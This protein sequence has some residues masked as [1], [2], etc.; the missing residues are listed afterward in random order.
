M[1]VCPMNR[2]QEKDLIIE[3]AKSLLSS[4]SQQ[5]SFYF[6]TS[7]FQCASTTLNNK[8]NNL[9]SM[10][11][12]PRNIVLEKDGCDNR[13]ASGLLT[14]AFQV[15]RGLQDALG[16]N[17]RFGRHQELHTSTSFAQ[18]HQGRITMG[19]TFGNNTGCFKTAL[20]NIN[21]SKIA[22]TNND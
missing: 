14:L 20:E 6:V 15:K 18:P 4:P 12:W 21:K 17:I 10:T 16:Q 2:G 5:G 7:R 11:R 19:K 8:C 22:R 9:G 3:C 1:A 13:S